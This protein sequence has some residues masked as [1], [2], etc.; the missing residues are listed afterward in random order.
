MVTGSFCNQHSSVLKSN[1]PKHVINHWKERRI[2][3]VKLIKM[4]ED[5]LEA[6]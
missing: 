5:F 1:D 2:K 6:T 4:L 3:I